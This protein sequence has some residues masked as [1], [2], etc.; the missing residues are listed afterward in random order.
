ML[1]AYHWAK[2]SAYL[3]KSSKIAEI[4]THAAEKKYVF[5]YFNDKSLIGRKAPSALITEIS[6]VQSNDILLSYIISGWFAS[7]NNWYFNLHL[8]NLLSPP[9]LFFAD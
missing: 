6:S 7:A 3:D 9:D 1:A 5:L 8:I 4:V 2:P